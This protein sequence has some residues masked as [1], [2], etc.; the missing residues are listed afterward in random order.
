MTVKLWG[1]GSPVVDKQIGVD[2][3]RSLGHVCLSVCVSLSACFIQADMHV[4]VFTH[5]A[6]TTVAAPSCVF[7]YTLKVF[8]VYFL[9][10]SHSEEIH[11]AGCRKNNRGAEVN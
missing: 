4:C 8:G 6:V 11:Q 3:C 9:K 10:L 7:I 5:K 2:L 1:K